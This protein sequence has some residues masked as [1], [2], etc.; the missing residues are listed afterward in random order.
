MD[1][2]QISKTLLAEGFVLRHE[3]SKV[4][5]YQSGTTDVYLK[6][7]GTDRPLV[8]HG[9]HGPNVPALLAISGVRREKPS[10]KPYH[11]IHMTRFDL[12]LNR[13]KTPTRFGFDFGFDDGV[14]LKAFIGRISK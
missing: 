10:T 6:Q 8:I 1:R 12:R 2:D 3:T 9:R 5:L 4:A 14:A 7:S 11:N 13:G